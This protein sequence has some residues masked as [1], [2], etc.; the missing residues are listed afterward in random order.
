MCLIVGE[1]LFIECSLEF[2]A[3][4]MISWSNRRLYNVRGCCSSTIC[5][6]LWV[7]WS[8]GPLKRGMYRG[9]YAVKGTVFGR[10]SSTKTVC[11]VPVYAGLIRAT[12][13]VAWN[14]LKGNSRTLEALRKNEEGWCEDGEG[15]FGYWTHSSRVF[16]WLKH[17]LLWD[18]R[19]DT[20]WITLRF[21]VPIY[22]SAPTVLKAY[23][24]YALMWEEFSIF[25][26]MVDCVW[27]Y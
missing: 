15:F 5:N 7:C 26:V 9:N 27:V 23:P 11:Q 1:C 10:V 17:I 4:S 21:P 22:S 24:L 19:E 2:E 18:W 25:R 6:W 12:P 3:H 16:Q 20:P 13:D 8:F 14:T